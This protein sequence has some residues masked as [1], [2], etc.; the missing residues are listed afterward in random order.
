M[1][2]VEFLGFVISVAAMIFLVIKRTYEE[3]QRRKNP[4]EYARKEKEREENLRKFLKERGIDTGDD[5]N[6]EQRPQRIK[7]IVQQPP[8][9]PQQKPPV[10]PQRKNL[11]PTSYGDYGRAAQHDLRTAEAYEVIR[12][13]SKSRGNLVLTGLTSQQNMLIIKEIFD[14]PLS[15]R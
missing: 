13:E 12:V 8:K 6:Q 9:A 14:K 4:V 2:F 10:I 7:K 11:T 1:S 3:R 15:M 5:L